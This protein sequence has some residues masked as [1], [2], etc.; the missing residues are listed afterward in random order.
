MP[1]V[2][3]KRYVV[4][5]VTPK[6]RHG[7]GVPLR[8][9]TPY[10]MIVVLGGVDRLTHMRHIA[11]IGYFVLALVTFLYYVSLITI[12]QV[13]HRKERAALETSKEEEMAELFS[14][15]RSSLELTTNSNN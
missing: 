8:Y 1:T 10:I 13:M 7:G 2:L 14:L 5:L 15:S 12:V 4:W 9:L 3:R 6:E 11:Q